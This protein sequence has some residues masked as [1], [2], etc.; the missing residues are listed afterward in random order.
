MRA[1]D[2]CSDDVLEDPALPPI[3][4]RPGSLHLFLGH[5]AV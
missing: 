3:R 4:A 5:A 1:V 2:A